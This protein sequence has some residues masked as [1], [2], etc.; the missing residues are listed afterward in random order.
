MT[1]MML[2]IRMKMPTMRRR[3]KLE[4]AIVAIPTTRQR[5]RTILTTRRGVPAR[6]SDWRTDCAQYQRRQS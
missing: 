3:K 4:G 6:H 1:M 2:M 5:T